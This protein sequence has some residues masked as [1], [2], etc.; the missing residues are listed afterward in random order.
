MLLYNCSFHSRIHCERTNN[1]DDSVT[2]EPMKRAR[3]VQIPVLISSVGGGSLA[4][5]FLKSDFHHCKVGI[6]PRS[7]D[8]I[9]GA[10]H[11]DHMVFSCREARGSKICQRNIYKL[12]FA[13]GFSINQSCLYP[14]VCL[15]ISGIT[16]VNPLCLPSPL[17]CHLLLTAFFCF[18]VSPP[19]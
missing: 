1:N 5:P 2:F 4:F 3:Q 8:F 11:L 18:H 7:S 15:A 19:L 6:P 13:I 14:W 12:T 17:G 10:F 9:S 16:Q